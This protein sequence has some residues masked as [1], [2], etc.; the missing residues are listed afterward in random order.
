MHTYIHTYT[1]VKALQEETGARVRFV[2]G[3]KNKERSQDSDSE[4]SESEASEDAEGE[5]TEK[6]EKG[7]M[8]VRGT[9]AQCERAYKIAQVCVCI[10]I[11][12]YMY[13]CVYVYYEGEKDEK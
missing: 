7:F 11:H 8:I 13:R 9:P 5:K 12:V 1:Q 10:Y 6:D 4:S 3:N 2:A